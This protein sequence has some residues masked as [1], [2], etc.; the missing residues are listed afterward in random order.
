[1][2]EYT[3]NN[4]NILSKG[5]L[6]KYDNK[7]CSNLVLY[8]SDVSSANIYLFNLIIRYQCSFGNSLYGKNNY[9]KQKKWSFFVDVESRASIKWFVFFEIKNL[10]KNNE[11]LIILNSCTEKLKS[12]CNSHVLKE[13]IESYRIQVQ[14]INTSHISHW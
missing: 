13:Q 12:C 2:D 1:M 9:N 8:L 10:I 6:I 11:M 5:P 4:G 7:I 3:F 14:I